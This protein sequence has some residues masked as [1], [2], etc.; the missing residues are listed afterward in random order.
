VSIEAASAEFV[1]LSTLPNFDPR[2]IPVVGVDS[3]LPP[4]PLGHLTADALVHR[5]DV[6][7]Q[8]TPEI[9]REIRFTNRSPAR[10]SVL[11][12]LVMRDEPM[13]VLTQRT[14]HMSTHSGQ[15]A[16]P[17]GKADPTDANEAATALREAHEEVGL[18]PNLVRVLGNLPMYTTGTAF[19]I[20]PVIGLVSPDFVPQPNPSE[21]AD[22]FEVPLA[23]LMNPANHHRHEFEWDGRKREWF[24][25]PYDVNTASSTLVAPEHTRF[26]WGATAGI[27]RNL[28]RFLSA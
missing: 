26:I 19:L 14:A 27:L 18:D 10:A 9:F 1:P 23:F 3:H 20:T 24:S 28:Y 8:W 12:G 13:V 22:V 16:F 25:M 15:I 2:K 6:A 4:V 5:F 11:I 7:P 17:G 21:V